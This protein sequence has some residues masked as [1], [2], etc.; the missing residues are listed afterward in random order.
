[1][2]IS[3]TIAQRLGGSLKAGNPADGGAVF[4]LTLDAWDETP[5]A[6]R[7]GER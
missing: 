2:S 4:T 3:H 1:V 6:V 5:A 7:A